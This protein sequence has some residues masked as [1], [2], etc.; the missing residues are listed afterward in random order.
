M[1]LN[2]ANSFNEIYTKYYRKSYLYVKSYIHDDMASE[3]I[4]SEAL[5]KLWE[6]M[7][8]GPLDTVLP[9]LFT[10]LKNQSLDYLKHKVIKKNVHEAVRDALKRELEIRTTT[11][12]ASD[13]VDIFSVEVQQI[14]ET[15]LNS[16]PERTREIF[17]MSR[18]GNKPHKEIA[19]LNKV[20]VKGVDYHIMQSVKALR[21]ALKDYLPFLGTLTFLH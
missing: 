3:D 17:I 1:Y 2:Q 18:F 15:T 12:E 8:Q 14:I 5:I 16:L 6:K 10:I 4:V 21:I 20:T 9:F 19:E 7:K 13:P 11:L